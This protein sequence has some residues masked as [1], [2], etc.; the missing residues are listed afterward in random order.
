MRELFREFVAA[1]RRAIADRELD[2]F[3]AWHVAALTAQASVG[4]LPKLETLL[5]RNQVQVQSVA[6]QRHVLGALADAYGLTLRPRST[7]G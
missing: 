6:T 2:L 4:K 5:R 1:K 7:R 3:R